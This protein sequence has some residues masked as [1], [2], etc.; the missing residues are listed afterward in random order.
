M[1]VLELMQLHFIIHGQ[2]WVSHSDVMKEGII[3]HHQAS[4]FG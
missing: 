3:N 1:A 4:V 2:G